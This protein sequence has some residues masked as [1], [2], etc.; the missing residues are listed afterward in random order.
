ML[1]NP[2]QGSVISSRPDSSPDRR[3]SKFANNPE[4][5]SRRF[6]VS[7]WVSNLLNTFGTC[8]LGHWYSPLAGQ[9]LSTSLTSAIF[10]HIH[11]QFGQVWCGLIAITHK[12]DW[13]QYT[14]RASPA[15]AKNSSNVCALFATRTSTLIAEFNELATWAIVSIFCS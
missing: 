13:P 3:T 15:D 7:Q 5:Q 9:Y 12:L 10:L 8:G 14:H 11:E 6:A 2:C 4:G 1:L